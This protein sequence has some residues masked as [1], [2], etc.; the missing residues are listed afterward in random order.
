M[1]EA[2]PLRPELAAVCR[3]LVLKRADRA[4]RATPSA[5]I[6]AQLASGQGLQ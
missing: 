2:T 5:G 4:V 1:R 3:Y 6:L